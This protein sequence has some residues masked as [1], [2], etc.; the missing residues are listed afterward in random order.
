MSKEKTVIR[1]SVLIVAAVTLLIAS[2]EAGAAPILTA[3][4][5]NAQENSPTTPTLGGGAP[6]SASFGTAV[7]FLN[8]VQTALAFSATIFNIDVRGR[9]RRMLM[10]T[11]SLRIS[12]RVR[13][14]HPLRM[15]RLCG[16]VFGS[17]FNDNNPNDFVLTPFSTSEAAARDP[18]IGN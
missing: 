17:P 7:F 11:S 16:G 13:P 10:T 14:L 15:A 12:M 1:L 8:D 9:K 18:L 5:S 6:R 4:L 3:N 2:A